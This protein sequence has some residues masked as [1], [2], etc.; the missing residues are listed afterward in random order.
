MERKKVKNILMYSD[1]IIT[2]LFYIYL[3][4]YLFIR[5]DKISIYFNYIL[6]LLLGIH[7]GYRYMIWV[8][9]YLKK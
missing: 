8:S 2:Y 7:L 6:I 4:I 3:S 9:E 5:L 1:Y